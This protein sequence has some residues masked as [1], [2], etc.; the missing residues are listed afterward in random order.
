MKT[1]REELAKY[2]HDAW[3]GWMKYLFEKSTLN[4]D[5]TITIPAWA[6]K[7]WKRQVATRYEYLPDEEQKS[8]LAEADKMLDIVA[9]CEEL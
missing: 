8:D 1:L 2:A 3:A 4:E 5:G 6:V 7:R 9:R